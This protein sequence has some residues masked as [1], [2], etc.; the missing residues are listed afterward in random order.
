MLVGEGKEGECLGQERKGCEAELKWF[1]GVEDGINETSRLFRPLIYKY[2][3]AS[4]AAG[5]CGVWAEHNN[6]SMLRGG[7]SA[8]GKKERGMRQ[9]SRDV[10]G[11]IG[12]KM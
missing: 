1:W 12:W 11:F 3:N 10:W 4:W 7:G 5:E 8:L 9:S 6:D 2:A